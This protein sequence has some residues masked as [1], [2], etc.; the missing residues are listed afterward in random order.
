[1]GKKFNLLLLVNSILIGFLILSVSSMN[2]T[3]YNMSAVISSGGNN[4]TTGNYS[5]VTIVGEI[6]GNASTSVYGTSLGFLLGVSDITPPGVIIITPAA[7][8]YNS[9]TVGIDIRLDEAGSCEYTTNAGATN[10]T[11]TANASNSGF[12]GT[13]FLPNGNYIFTAYCNDSAG[14]QN[15]T[16]NVSFTF[17][18]IPAPPT[19]SG[20]ESSG[21]GGDGVPMAIQPLRFD[22]KPESF[23]ETLVT[24]LGERGKITITNKEPLARTF[25]ASVN[26]PLKEIISFDKVSLAIGSKE[27]SE[28]G[29]DIL[30][31]KEP[32]IYTG[33][34]IITTGHTSKVVFVTV[35]VRTEKSLFDVILSIPRSMKTILVGKNIKAQI[36]LIQMGVL[37]K[38]DVTLNYM[39][40]DFEGKTYF[41]ESETIMVYE[42]KSFEK[43]FHTQEFLP[44]DYVIG[45]ELIYPDGVAVSSSQFKIKE[46]IGFIRD[47]LFFISLIGGMIA[48]FVA[49]IFAIKRYKRIKLRSIHRKKDGRK[50]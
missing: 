46:S 42:K 12:T 15:Y 44:G 25:Q 21:G 7:T 43:E 26:E 1:M 16:E 27:S 22:V 11:L 30:A 9:R 32:G 8:A 28:L 24:N 5:Q 39:I 14:N 36:N 38:M 47:N 49:V 50:K 20:S 37:E 40:K 34:I 29:F 23:T 17:N 41:S 4:A 10:G 48:L 13:T 19:S 6:N 31:P 2:S 45:V 33:K 18:L 35:N 3:N